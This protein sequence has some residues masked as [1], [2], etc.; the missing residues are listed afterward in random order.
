MS[1]AS[2]NFSVKCDVCNT[3]TTFSAGESDFQDVGGDPDRGMGPE[4][5]YEW[6]NSFSCE[7][8]EKE[9]EFVYTA[10]EY[11]VNAYDSEDLKITG[12]EA[13]EKYTFDFSEGPDP[14][15]E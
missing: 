3:V 7:G 1:I 6:E 12:G 8:C 15:D 5:I 9:I 13:T 11:P 2:G 10:V 14:D 4:T